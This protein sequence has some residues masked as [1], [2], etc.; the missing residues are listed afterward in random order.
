MN[1]FQNEI[2]FK[3]ARSGGPGGQNVNKVETAVDACWDVA[4]SSVFTDEEK[5]RIL[6]KLASKLNKDEVLVVRC[7]ETRSQLENKILAEKKLVELVR[8]SLI[9][10]K[11]RKASK[12]SAAAKQKRLDSKKRLSDKKQNRRGDW[13]E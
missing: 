7:T 11:P 5:E 13:G 3:T 4:R 1:H 6:H 8:K 2:F 12:P 9:Q 10:P